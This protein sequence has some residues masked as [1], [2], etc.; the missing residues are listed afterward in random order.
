MRRIH[1]VSRRLK[2]AA[3]AAVVAA[4]GALQR[5]LG[6][7]CAVVRREL[8]RNGRQF[9]AGSAAPLTPLLAPLAWVLARCGHGRALA[10]LW[11]LASPLVLLGGLGAGLALGGMALTLSTPGGR[12]RW[13]SELARGLEVAA[14]RAVSGAT[15]VLVA[16][17]GWL[18]LAWGAGAEGPLARAGLVGTL[19]IWGYARCWD[20]LFRGVWRL[21]RG[22]RHPSAAL[23]LA[24]AVIGLLGVWLVVAAVAPLL[25]RA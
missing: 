5:G 11:G 9:R 13:A 8:R 2:A 10:E 17:G 16:L 14:W 20:A 22:V 6:A 15:A 4:L 25:G 21:S 3:W 12:L 24:G 18:V 7:A 19:A 1:R 23:R